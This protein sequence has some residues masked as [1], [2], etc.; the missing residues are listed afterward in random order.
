MTSRRVEKGEQLVNSY[1]QCELCGNRFYDYT[2]IDIFLDYGFVESYPQK[3]MIDEVRLKFEVMEPEDG[4]DGLKIKWTMP[5]SVWGVAWLKD[6]V[7]RL[8]QFAEDKQNDTELE[9]SMPQHEYDMVWMLQKAAL[10]AFEAAAK[11]SEGLTSGAAWKCDLGWWEVEDWE[12]DPC[13][14]RDLRHNYALLQEDM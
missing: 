10:S 2:T 1:N 4:S 12:E 14:E 3:W 13:Y 8:R 6:E 5:P 11:Q 9:K 7:A